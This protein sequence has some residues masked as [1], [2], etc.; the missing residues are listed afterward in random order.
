ML[1]WGLGPGHA[2]PIHLA[3]RSSLKKEIQ[4]LEMF[5]EADTGIG[6]VMDIGLERRCP[7][8]KG[9]NSILSHVCPS[10]LT[11][12]AL[13][14]GHCLAGTLYCSW[15]SLQ[16]QSRLTRALLSTLM[17][18]KS[19]PHFASAAWEDSTKSPSLI[20]LIELQRKG[21]VHSASLNPT[22]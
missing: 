2:G 9:P 4:N 10:S 11:T 14:A 7:W 22:P 16:G 8:D 17:D 19:A 18:L 5:K 1:E 3:R 21:L 20:L 6:G 13:S 12:L 15:H